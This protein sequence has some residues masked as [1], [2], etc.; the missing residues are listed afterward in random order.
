VVR[1]LESRSL[2]A[3]HAIERYQVKNIILQRALLSIPACAPWC[4]MSDPRHVIGKAGDAV[5]HDSHILVVIDHQCYPVVL[6]RETFIE[7]Y[8]GQ[9]PTRT[10]RRVQR[11]QS[12]NEAGSY[13]I[14]PRDRSRDRGRCLSKG[15]MG[16]WPR[17]NRPNVHFIPV[18]ALNGCDFVNEHHHVM[19][20]LRMTMCAAR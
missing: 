2:A 13:L 18:C 8:Y 6:Q 17:T 14:V 1:Q 11:L 4:W 5:G 20:L 7:K 15:I 19:S 10:R 9:E 3:N 12:K 16:Q